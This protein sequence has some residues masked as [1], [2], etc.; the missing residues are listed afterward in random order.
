MA[1][2]T[3][4]ISQGQDEDLTIHIDDVTTSV[5]MPTAESC[6][7]SHASLAGQVFDLL[8]N[9][10]EPPIALQKMQFTTNSHDVAKL[11]PQAL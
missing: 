9:K 7:N 6:L 8:T 2:Y 10:L 3:T 4:E 1:P 5:A 11:A